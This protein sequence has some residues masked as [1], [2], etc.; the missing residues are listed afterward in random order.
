MT[1]ASKR[2]LALALVLLQLLTLLP[3]LSLRA[4]AADPAAAA[5]R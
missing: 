4:E 5:A 3:A 2:C 1:R